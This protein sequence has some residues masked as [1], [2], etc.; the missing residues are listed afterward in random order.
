MRILITVAHYFR[1]VSD[2]TD[3][4]STRSDPRPR[5]GA[6]TQC[7][8]SFRS[9][10]GPHGGM[11]DHLNRRVLNANVPDSIQY[12]VVVCTTRG[13]H[14]LNH[15]PPVVGDFEHRETDAEPL[16]LGYECHA[17]LKERLGRYD[18][19]GYVEDDIIATDPWMFR[20]L[21]WFNQVVGNECLLQPN[22]FE[23]GFRQG[24][25][26]RK[27]YVDGPMNPRHADAFQD[28]SNSPILV[29]NLLGIPVRFE[30]PSN[31][32]SGC[33]FLN[34]GQMEVWAEKPYFLD[35]SAAFYK[36]LESAATLGILR[37]FRIYKPIANNADFLEIQHAGSAFHS[38][39]SPPPLPTASSAAPVS[40]VRSDETA[41]TSA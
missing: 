9:L 13:C 28:R 17:V 18:Y 14:L 24:V 31:P 39:L 22:R 5:V 27:L 21:A 40:E 29:A 12:D 36:A 15:L 33:F 25:T 35:R 19:Y 1:A 4:G 38:L 23:Y 16:Q 41:S 10:Y 26:V 11:L 30:R 34:A 2:A 7:L 8:S 6:L 20:K 3:H 32:H 37:T